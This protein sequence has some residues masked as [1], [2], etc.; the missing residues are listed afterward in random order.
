MFKVDLPQKIAQARK[1]SGLTQE[2]LAEL[3][4]VTVRTICQV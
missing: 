3:T 4:H 2:Q 1:K